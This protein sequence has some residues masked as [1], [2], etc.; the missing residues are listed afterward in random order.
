MKSAVGC[1]WFS[2][3]STTSW[4]TV[5]AGTLPCVASFA[6]SASTTTI[7]RSVNSSNV[8]LL[9][10]SIHPTSCPETVSLLV[11]FTVVQNVVAVIVTVPTV[12]SDKS[13]VQVAP[14][15]QPNV[16]EIVFSSL[17]SPSAFISVISA[18]VKV[19]NPANPGA[20]NPFNLVWKSLSHV[21]V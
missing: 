9:S 11:A 21:E 2:Q 15:A 17:A 10:K 5:D 1:V 7:E 14:I 6:V 20:P 16:S 3:T 19:A 13:P 4:S 12:P 8:P 18:V